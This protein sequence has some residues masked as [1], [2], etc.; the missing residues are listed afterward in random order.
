MIKQKDYRICKILSL[1]FKRLQTTWK[2]A[3]KHLY[4]K[5]IPVREY[6]T[7]LRSVSHV[8]TLYANHGEFRAKLISFVRKN[9]IQFHMKRLLLI[10]L[11]ALPLMGFAQSITINQ[12]KDGTH[13]VSTDMQI[14]RSF[15]DKMVLSV[16]MFAGKD[17]TVDRCSYFLDLKITSSEKIYIERGATLTLWLK[18]GDVIRLSAV[19]DNDNGMVRD[20]HVINGF[21]THDYS[22]Y[23]TFPVTESQLN[24]I[25]S[26]GVEQIQCNTQPEA[27]VKEF[28]KDKIG[29]AIGE[30]W[31]LLQKT[32]FPNAKTTSSP[33]AKAVIDSDK[34]TFFPKLFGLNKSV[35]FGILGAGMDSFDYGAI[36]FN[37]TVFGV[38][39]DF[40][41]WPRKH[42][43]SVEVEQ[44]KDH[45][46]WATHI[47]YQ[48]PFHYY[49]GGSIRL[50][51]MVGYASI[52]EGITDGSDW[53]VSQGGINNKFRV[54]EQKGGFDY[55]AALVFQ[56]T[57]PKI[58]AY[59]LSL[60]ATKH[61]IWLGLAWEFQFSK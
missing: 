53:D 26:K 17:D 55:G 27:Y 36:G 34:P 42:A 52:K 59:N 33:K 37:A 6:F 10:V 35:S 38:Y 3:Y 31:N 47:G 7:H 29:K 20:I 21:V 43:N 40:M 50:V 19:D 16:G 41:G 15:A 61:T 24:D 39:V 58:G 2:R 32:L 8:P 56:N 1:I 23:P 60:G 28:K 14:C 46:V 45:S 48:I 18:G 22:A 12:H 57:D 30:R 54:T 25:V 5:T 44:W 51:P 13:I 11:L 9:G 4:H 49:K